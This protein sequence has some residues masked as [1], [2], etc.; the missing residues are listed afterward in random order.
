V[1]ERGKKRKKTELPSVACNKTIRREQGPPFLRKV[2]EPG[3]GGGG[4]EEKNILVLQ[5]ERGICRGGVR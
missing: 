2:G 1:I 4:G 5:P 3:G